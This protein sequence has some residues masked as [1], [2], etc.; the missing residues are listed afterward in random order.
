MDFDE[1]KTYLEDKYQVKVEIKQDEPFTG[2]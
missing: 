1:V 2:G